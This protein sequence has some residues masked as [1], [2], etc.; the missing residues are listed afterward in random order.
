MA[1]NTTRSMEYDQQELN[2][3]I[4]SDEADYVLLGIPL[5]MYMA[6]LSTFIQIVIQAGDSLPV[7]IF[8]KFHNS[9]FD[10]VK[11]LTLPVGILEVRC[12][13]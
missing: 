4:D 5:H 6:Y 3:I 13:H 8:C 10:L 2:L 12:I 7:H 1:G 9:S 11:Y